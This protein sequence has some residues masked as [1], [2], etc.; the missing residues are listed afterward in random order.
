VHAG[1]GD[2]VPALANLTQAVL[3]TA[4]GRLAAAGHWV[5]NEKRLVARADLDAAGS[6]LADRSREL[7]A[8]AAEL[9][10]LLRLPGWGR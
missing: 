3:A 10:D 6:L 7:T 1:R 9:A 2:P 5:L 4:H 8:V